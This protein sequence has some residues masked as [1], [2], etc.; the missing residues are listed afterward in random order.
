MMCKIQIS[1][2]HFCSGTVAGELLQLAMLFSFGLLCLLFVYCV[3]LWVAS[4]V[5]LSIYLV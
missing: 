1:H 4:D 5:K 3:Y 2:M